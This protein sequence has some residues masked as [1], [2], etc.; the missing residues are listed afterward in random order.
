M[1]IATGEIE[2]TDFEE[3]LF[4]VQASD[5]WEHAARYIDMTGMDYPKK[6]IGSIAPF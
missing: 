4:G 5:V 2:V 1:R 3:G 6:H